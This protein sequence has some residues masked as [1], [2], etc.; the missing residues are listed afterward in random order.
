MTTDFNKDGHFY[1]ENDIRYP[2][3]TTVLKLI[4][5]DENMLQWAYNMG[6]YRQDINEIKNKACNFGTL[7]HSN[8][9]SIVDPNMD[10]EDI[11]KPN[12]P[13]EEFDLKKAINNFKS[14]FSDINYDTIYTEHTIIDPIEK[15]A[16]TLDWLAIVDNSLWLFDFKTS[17]RPYE[18][19]LIQLGAYAHLIEYEGVYHYPDKAGIIIANKFGGSLHPISKYRLKGYTDIFLKLNELY[20]SYTNLDFKYEYEVSPITQENTSIIDKN[21]RGE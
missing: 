6:K 2:S 19:Y 5:Y 21:K 15:Y 20:Q 8:L 18:K 4:E 12:N 11:L 14:L 10:K 1:I 17:K 16:G 13:F 3:V 9:Q 7:T